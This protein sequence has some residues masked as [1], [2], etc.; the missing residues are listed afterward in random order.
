[1]HVIYNRYMQIGFEGKS[2]A[3]LMM[4]EKVLIL[5]ASLGLICRGLMFVSFRFLTFCYVGIGA[6]HASARPC[7]H[8]FQDTL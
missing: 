3:G 6:C 2:G 7:L 8:L 4:C 1:M 5:V